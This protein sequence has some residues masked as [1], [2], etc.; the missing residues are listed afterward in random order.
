MR[1]S[2]PISATQT[3]GPRSLKA[4]FSIVL[5]IIYPSVGDLKQ[6]GILVLA[7]CNQLRAA[8]V[9]PNQGRIFAMRCLLIVLVVQGVVS[10]QLGV[11]HLRQPAPSRALV[12]LSEV[13]LANDASAIRVSGSCAAS[14]LFKLSC[15]PRA[16]R[17]TAMPCGLRARSSEARMKA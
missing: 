10:L 1:S 14:Q 16:A 11:V 4:L 13:L 3:C 7:R 2:C 17:S 8:R 6:C 5:S 15:A 9:A 12:V